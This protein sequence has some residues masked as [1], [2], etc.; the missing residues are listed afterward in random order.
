MV[1]PPSLIIPEEELSASPIVLSDSGSFQIGS[2]RIDSKGFTGLSHSDRRLLPFSSSSS[3]AVQ[4]I[5][6]EEAAA[7]AATPLS[8]SATH[9]RSTPLSSSTPLSASSTHSSFSAMSSTSSTRSS[10]ASTASS[11]SLSSLPSFRPLSVSSA[12]SLP[13]PFSSFTLSDIQLDTTVDARLGRG[14]S[15]SV[16]RA[17]H[18]PSGTPLAVKQIPIDL[19]EAKSK[20]IV[21]ELRTLHTSE[22]RQVVGFYGAFYRERMMTLVL[23]Y[24]DV[25]SLKD[26]MTR[27]KENER[28]GLAGA[29]RVTEQLVSL[30]CHEV[31][32]ALHYLHS[33]KRLIHRD[34]KP[35]NI[36]LNSRGDVKLADFGV[37]GEVE[38]DMQGKM[39]FVGTLIYMSPERITGAQHGYDSDVWSLGLTMM[40]CLLGRFPYQPTT[41]DN[42]KRQV[43]LQQHQTANGALRDDRAGNGRHATAA[44]INGGG[45]G[46]EKTPM[47]ASSVLTQRSFSLSPTAGPH[48]SPHTP[49][50]SSASS[51]L[52]NATNTTAQTPPKLLRPSPTPVSSSSLTAHTQTLIDTLPPAPQ[53]QMKRESSFCFWGAHECIVK[54]PPPSLPVEQFSSECRHFFSSCLQKESGQ[55]SSAS[56]LLHHPFIA[57][58]SK[59][60]EEDRRV[61]KEWISTEMAASAMARSSSRVRCMQDAQ[62]TAIANEEERK[63]KSSAWGSSTIDPSNAHSLTILAQARTP[64]AS[65]PASSAASSVASS[66]PASGFSSVATSNQ[67]SLAATPSYLTPSHSTSLTPSTYHST[68]TSPSLFSSPIVLPPLPPLTK[69]TSSVSPDLYLHTSTSSPYSSTPSSSLVRGLVRLF[70]PLLSAAYRGAQSQETAWR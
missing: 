34:I 50:P 3:T 22:C 57:R 20:Q 25:G 30:L 46:G 55:R 61:L 56:E 70:G 65:T 44:P 13:S 18:I 16:H 1:K 36:L 58:W 43:A 33:V 24:M 15:G 7:A 5:Q 41:P 66:Q 63:R 62:T 8:S 14:A 19:S 69:S 11:A 64:L 23:E 10:A 27:V 12:S 4:P 38:A 54:D 6:E 21:T 28:R 40:E 39:T 37:S 42:R 53:P 67:S 26:F 52:Y 49:S 47:S 31:L 9:I 48:L 68:V 51:Y 2:F 17:T 29:G 45:V 60:E 59:G 35:S 32:L